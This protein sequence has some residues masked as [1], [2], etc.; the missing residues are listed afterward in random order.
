MSN[1]WRQIF[2]LPMLPVR[3][4]HEPTQ[5]ARD[6]RRFGEG[7]P[8][9]RQVS[10]RVAPDPD[11]L[12]SFADAVARSRNPGLVL[13]AGIDRS[14][15]WEAAVMLA[16]RVRAPVGDSLLADAGLACAALAALMPTS[17]RP[18]LS[19]QAAPPPP[20]VGTPLSAAALFATLAQAWPQDAI[21]VEESPS[22][23]ALLHRYVQITRPLSF[24]TM[25][26]GGLGFGLPAAIGVALAE[27]HTSRS[28]PVIAVIGDGSFHYAVQAL[29]TA[30]REQLPVVFVVP[31]NQEYDILKSFAELLKTPGVPG[32]DLPGLDPVTI[33]RGYGCSAEHA[34]SADGVV[35]ALRRAL[36]ASGPTVLAVPISREVP[37]LL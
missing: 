22:N 10:T 28:R 12:Q 18:R 33:A 24:F 6:I 27:R 8:A 36:Q 14:G 23:L 21:L 30:A 37:P 35:D 16:E 9:V 3:F 7:N 2:Q 13:G 17:D 15:G 34:P 32:L 29:W 19:P 5:L 25:A 26:S 11:R 31:V 1:I 20:S 4:C